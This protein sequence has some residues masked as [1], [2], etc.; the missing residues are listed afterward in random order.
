MRKDND[1]AK[2]VLAALYL[3]EGGKNRKGALMFGNSNPEIISLF[4]NL[5]RC[6]YQIENSKFRCTLLCRAD[7][8]LEKS[9]SFWVSITGVPKE[10]FYKPRIDSRTIGKKSRNP[11]YK[12]VCRIDY[13][14][15]QV[16]NDLT[17]AGDILTGTV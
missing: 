16:Y 13:F 15:A 14:S 2:A 9:E 6:V 1:F 10:Q 17:A 5:L 7:Q 11:E 4:L 12:G 3:A 8:N